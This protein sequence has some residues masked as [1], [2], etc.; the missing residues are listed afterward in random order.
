[1]EILGAVIVALWL[2]AMIWRVRDTVE[3]IQRE[4]REEIL[5]RSDGIGQLLP[6]RACW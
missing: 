6:S 3:Q 1:V 5:A 4:Q 2:G